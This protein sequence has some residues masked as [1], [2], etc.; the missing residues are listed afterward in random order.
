VVRTPIAE[1]WFADPER[2]RALVGRIPLGRVASLDDVVGPVLF[3]LGDG[4][5]FVTGQVLY[6]DGGITA[7]Q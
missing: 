4:A 6:V 3:F 1:H 5:A 2:Q 7:T